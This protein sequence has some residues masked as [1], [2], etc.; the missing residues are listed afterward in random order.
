MATGYVYDP[1]FLKHAMPGH[2]EGP[3]RLRAI[4]EELDRARLLGRLTLMPARLATVEELARVHTPA[5][6]EY[7]ERL[8]DEGG[9]EWRGGETYVNEFTY[10]AA[11]FAAGGCIGAAEA[12]WRGRIDNAIA[13]VRPPGHHASRDRGEGFCLFNNVALAARALQELGAARVMI[14]DFDLHHGQGTQWTFEDEASVLYFSTH[15][16]GIYPGTG[17]YRESGRGPGTGYTVNVPLMPGAGDQTYARVYERILTPLA[18]RFRPEILLVS[19]GYDIHWTDPLGSML[20]TLP[21]IGGIVRTLHDLAKRLC[22][23]KLVVCLEGGYSLQA[24]ALGVANTVRVLLGDRQLQDPL[25][26]PRQV[27]RPDE[28]NE[29][30]ATIVRKHDL[31]PF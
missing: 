22:R 21:G 6:I 5:Y 25:G 24:Q 16:W 3:E 28:Y 8:S 2:M 7:V 14:V 23:G 1:L 11:R 30:I 26:A 12:V 19:A 10:E 27:E 18:E 13:L 4:M 29:L 31:A 20:V 9:G 15:Q 17:H